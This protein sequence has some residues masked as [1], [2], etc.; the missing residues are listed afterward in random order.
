MDLI[1]SFQEKQKLQHICRAQMQNH[2]H[3]RGILVASFQGVVR[4]EW[5][6]TAPQLRDFTFEV[7]KIL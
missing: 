5:R 3:A 1:E 2:H 6:G 4:R 7:M